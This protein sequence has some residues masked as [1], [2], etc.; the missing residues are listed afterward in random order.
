MAAKMKKASPAPSIT[1][2][3]EATDCTI[4]IGMG[5]KST[6]GPPWAKKEA[7]TGPTSIRWKFEWSAFGSKPAAARLGCQTGI[8]P[9]LTT[10][11]MPLPMVPSAAAVI[12]G[13]F[14]LASSMAASSTYAT[15]TSHIRTAS[16]T[17]PAAS[18]ASSPKR[19]PA[20]TSRTGHGQAEDE[21]QKNAEDGHVLGGC[22]G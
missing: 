3:I 20:A 17:L 11:A 16:G 22:A 9:P 10:M 12:P 18:A 1:S 13:R 15:S 2:P 14:R 6:S 21:P 4:G 7:S 19:A 5:M 8:Q